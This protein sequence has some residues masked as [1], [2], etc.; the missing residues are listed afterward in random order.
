MV[1]NIV[2]Q[3]IT[4]FSMSKLQMRKVEPD[5]EGVR[6]DRWFKRHF[7]AVTHG[8]LQKMLRTGQVRVAGKRADTSTRLEAGQ[9]IRIPPQVI[10]PPKAEVEKKSARDASDLKKLILFQDEDILVLNKPP[11]LAVQGGTGIRD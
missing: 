9:D 1:R 4:G 6:L 10:E 2:H 7:A 3:S 5:E 11:G 8:Q